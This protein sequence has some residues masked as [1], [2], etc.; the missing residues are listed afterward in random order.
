MDGP[1][2]RF[3]FT[4]LRNSGRHLGQTGKKQV[5]NRGTCEFRTRPHTGIIFRSPKIVC[6]SAGL[7]TMIDLRLLSVDQLL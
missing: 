3:R 7:R 6:A 2:F 5:F 4:I 1:T